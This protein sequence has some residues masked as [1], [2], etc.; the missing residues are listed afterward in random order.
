MRA[1]RTEYP[2]LF[3]DSDAEDG[4][5][6]EGEE[7]DTADDAGADSGFAGKW[8]WVASIDAVAET[9]GGGWDTATARPVREFLNILCY[10]NDKAAEQERQRKEYLRKH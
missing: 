10:R 6:Q 2:A 1:I 8:G 4:D 9:A 3:G 5:G 7:E